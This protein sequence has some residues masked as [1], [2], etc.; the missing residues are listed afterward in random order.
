M[1]NDVDFFSGGF[2]AKYGDKLSAVMDIKF[3]DGNRQ[4]HIRDLNVSATGFGGFFEGPI[5]KKSSY[6]FSVRRSYL[7][8]IKDE[9]TTSL[10]PEYWDFN[11]KLS[12]DLSKTDKIS[13]TG[14]FATDNAKP[15]KEG[16]FM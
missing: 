11:A 13:I 9:L 7:E 6:M 8:L 5:A 12:Y 10:I 14:L 3:K 2:P 1:V 4:R 15:L 16:D